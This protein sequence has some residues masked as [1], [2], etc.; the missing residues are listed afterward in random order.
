VPVAV[1][2]RFQVAMDGVLFIGVWDR[3]DADADNPRA[4]TI[5]DYKSGAQ[6]GRALTPARARESLQLRLYVLAYERLHGVRPVWAELESIEGGNAAGFAP[7]D[8]DLVRA[9]EAI[10]LVRDGVRAGRLH[11]TPSPGVCRTCSFR[12]ICPHSAAKWSS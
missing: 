3:V 6:A 11:A 10:R 8:S 1:E 4:I 2:E 9:A 7:A 5:T 12:L